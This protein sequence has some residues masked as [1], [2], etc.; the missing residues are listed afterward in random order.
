MKHHWKNIVSWTPGEPTEQ[1]T[2]CDNCGA[3]LNDEN[4][5]EECVED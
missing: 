4:E 1:F 3:E 2:V 5:D